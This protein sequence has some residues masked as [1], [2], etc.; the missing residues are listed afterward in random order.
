MPK[1]RFEAFTDAIIAIVMTVLVLN[2]KTPENSSVQALLKMGNQFLI[3]FISFFVLA[4]YWNNHHRLVT[5]TKQINGVVMWANNI[6]ILSLT[7]FPFATSWVSQY[8]HDLAPQVFYAVVF[9]LAD[10]FFYLLCVAFLRMPAEKQNEV[11]YFFKKRTLLTIAINIVSII[12]GIFTI[13]EMIIVINTFA[14]LPWITAY[15]LKPNF[16]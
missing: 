11:A 15:Q 14:L 2:L 9:F 5:S 10:S 7:L 12:V 1:N 4:I 6:F 3:Y 13:P 16:N 8:P